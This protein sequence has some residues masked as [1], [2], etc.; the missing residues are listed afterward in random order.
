MD[1]TAAADPATIDSLLDRAGTGPFQARLLGVFGLVWAADAMQVLAVG[2]TAPSVAAS[3][4]LTIPAA[5]QA[6]T[7]FFL[8]MF[9]GAP[10]FGALADRIGRRNV[11]IAT[12]GLDAVAG[13]L[14][15]F[16]PSF[17]ALVVLRFVTGLAV[18]GTLPVDYAM[19]A[20]VLPAK[21]RGRW[22]VGL[23]GFW[24]V[25]T[26]AVALAAWA[27]TSGGAAE[28]WRWIFAAA[29]LPALIG[30]GLRFWTP[31]SPFYLLKA[32]RSDEAKAVLNR[33]L[34]AN[35]RP[36][37]SGRLDGAASPRI[38][39]AGL[40]TG[41]HRRRTIAVLATWLLVSVAYYGVFTWLPGRL[42]GQGFGFVRGYGFL[43]LLALAQIPG[44]ALA[45]V[46]VEVWGRR[47]TL[48]GFLLLSAAACAAFV[49]ASDATAIAA[50]LLVLSFA[51]LG[52]WG[53][54]Y[55][56]TPELYPTAARASGM[57]LAGAAARLGGLLA[58]SA[59]APVIAMGFEPAMGI[60]AVLL[61]G[62]AGAT[63]MIPSETRGTPLA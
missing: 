52:S 22:L 54:L 17:A 20:E 5:L 45:A 30:I 46:G 40:L 56:Y 60:F 63:A 58:P 31:E 47:P 39:F 55:A 51:L 29:G 7:A 53:A 49:L 3:F 27:A 23:E 25:G 43:V 28:P 41:D 21:R 15:A 42:T 35:G 36:A 26:V 4:G 11:L 50:A 19:M 14:T 13:L 33:I 24:A 10:A 61:I 37:F 6:G 38:G 2:I 48:I 1:Q 44:Y 32:G 12:V 9:I 62:A 8:G 57:G 16:A 34:L 59:L 18:G